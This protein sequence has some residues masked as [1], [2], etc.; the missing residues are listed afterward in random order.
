VLVVILQDANGI[1]IDNAAINVRGDMNH[2]GMTPVL[3]DVNASSAGEYRVNFDWSMGGDW[4]LTITA[5][6]SD[7]SRAEAQF[8]VRVGA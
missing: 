7:G 6:L 8:N 3:R 4:I 2:A 5:I 1:P